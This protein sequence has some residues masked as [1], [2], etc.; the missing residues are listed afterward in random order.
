MGNNIYVASHTST[1]VLN[2]SIVVEELE[3]I[4]K[5]VVACRKKLEDQHEKGKRLGVPNS[6][7]EPC[8][9]CLD[10]VRS[11]PYK[12]TT[13]V[14][15]LWPNTSISIREYNEQIE[16]DSMSEETLVNQIT[17]N[18]AEIKVFLPN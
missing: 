12:L 5:Q 13:H 11:D 8:V 14:R 10:H 18:V 17:R 6:D 7:I 4:N 2:G 3:S 15:R 1:P 9:F 16:I